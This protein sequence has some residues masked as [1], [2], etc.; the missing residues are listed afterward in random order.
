LGHVFA[1]K[2]LLDE[3][4]AHSS[5]LGGRHSRHRSAAHERL[6]FLGDRVLGLVV[7]EALIERHPGEAEGALNLRLVELVRA[8]TQAQIATELGVEGW[9]R[10]NA[11]AVGGAVTATLLADTL[12]AL[13]AALYLDGGLDVARSFI[14]RHWSDRLA[15]AGP[16]RRD[17]KTKLQEWV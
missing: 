8:E 15:S 17:A 12:E 10:S 3:S 4:L 7:A 16:P 5:R 9:L 13:I 14:L 11:A 1:D 2:T 6:E